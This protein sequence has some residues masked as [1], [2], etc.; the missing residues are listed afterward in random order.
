VD[1]ALM[2]FSYFDEIRLKIKYDVA[3]F[4]I[5]K[6]VHA[7]TDIHFAY[8]DIPNRC[9]RPRK[10]NRLYSS[11]MLAD[12]VQELAKLPSRITIYRGVADPTHVGW[13]WSL[14]RPIAEWFAGR[15]P[16]FFGDDPVL[17]IGSARKADILAYFTV[18]REQEIL[19]SPKAVKVIAIEKNRPRS[20]SHIPNIGD[21]GPTLIW[22]CRSVRLTFANCWRRECAST[23]RASLVLRPAGHFCKTSMTTTKAIRVRIAPN[24]RGFDNPI[25]KIRMGSP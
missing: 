4:N 5:L 13:S 23:R 10:R 3:Y 22:F 24:R 1:N 6:M 7:L 19:I 9:Y 18:G 25:T 14:S 17:I 12:E 2:S 15:W 20:I 21:A 8:S 16:E 11:M